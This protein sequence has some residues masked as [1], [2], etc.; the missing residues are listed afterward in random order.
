MPTVNRW[1]VRTP[2]A[3]AVALITAST[4]PPAPDA[5]DEATKVALEAVGVQL[6]VS[7]DTLTVEGVAKANYPYLDRSVQSYKIGDPEGLLGVVGVGEGGAGG[8]DDGGES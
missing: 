6:G 5:Q 3:I 8:I 4:A 7:P 1:N 2:V